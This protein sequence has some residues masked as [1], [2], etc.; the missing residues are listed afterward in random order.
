MPVVDEKNALVV[1]ANM[2]QDGKMQS[3]GV[4]I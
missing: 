1:D 4:S 2:L 3:C